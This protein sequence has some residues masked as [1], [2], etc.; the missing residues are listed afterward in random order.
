MADEKRIY[1]PE[2]FLKKLT[3]GD[4]SIPVAFSGMVKTSKTAKDAILF[5][6]EQ[7][8]NWVEI[9]TTLIENVELV[10]VVPCKD[11][12]HPYVNISFKKPKS[13]EAE[14]FLKLAAAYAASAAS[15]NSDDDIANLIPISRYLYANRQTKEP[16]PTNLS[17]CVACL[18]ACKGVPAPQV[19]DCLAACGS[20]C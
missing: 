1:N 20:S 10:D 9:P 19:F 17:P 12:T 2:D 16:F 7:C 14:V 18:R 15:R 5:S 6:S 3:Q 4:I 13:A 8:S 11:H